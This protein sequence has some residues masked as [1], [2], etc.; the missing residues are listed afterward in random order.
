MDVEWIRENILL[1]GAHN[2]DGID[3]LVAYLNKQQF[4]KLTILLGI[5][6]GIKI[7]RYDRKN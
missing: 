7:T 2:N 5:L 4:S 6:E 1:D 3:S